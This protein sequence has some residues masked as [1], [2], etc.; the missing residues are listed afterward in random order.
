MDAVDEQLGKLRGS[1]AKSELEMK[2]DDTRDGIGE[3]TVV[4]KEMEAELLEMKEFVSKPALREEEK[5][6]A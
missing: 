2:H 4:L 1:V 6:A 5:L 3:V